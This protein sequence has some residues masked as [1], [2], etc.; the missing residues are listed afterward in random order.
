VGG[1]IRK[2]KTRRI[3]YY[4]VKVVQYLLNNKLLKAISHILIRES[5]PLSCLEIEERLEKVFRRSFTTDRISAQLRK[6]ER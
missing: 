1:S 4:P 3:K 5:T 2:R 6:P